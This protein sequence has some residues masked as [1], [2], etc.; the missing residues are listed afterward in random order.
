MWIPGAI[1][2]CA[3]LAVCKYTH[4]YACIPT[5]MQQA[6]QNCLSNINRCKINWC[7]AV[8]RDHSKGVLV[9]TRYRFIKYLLAVLLRFMD[10]GDLGL[11][12]FYPPARLYLRD[13]WLPVPKTLR[14]MAAAEPQLMTDSAHF[15]GGGLMFSRP[16]FRLQ[17]FFEALS[18]RWQ[19]RDCVVDHFM[20]VVYKT[21]RPLVSIF[22]TEAFFFVYY[23]LQAIQ[24]HSCPS[25]RVK[26]PETLWVNGACKLYS[27]WGVQPA[28]GASVTQ[29]AALSFFLS[30]KAKLWHDSMCLHVNWYNV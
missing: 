10:P 24:P 17:L 27:W 26:L 15:V 30:R 6:Q 9:C 28:C 2:L 13:E 19:R 12:R 25:L 1:S 21:S 29:K 22:F 23:P 14:G 7:Y 18:A 20:A 3:A 8:I 16:F 5:K 4:T 11:A